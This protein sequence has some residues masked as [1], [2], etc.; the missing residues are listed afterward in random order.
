[1]DEKRI[2][3]SPEM[4]YREMVRDFN[5]PE[6]AV[7]LV[8]GADFFYDEE[9]KI[10]LGNFPG[11]EDI[12]YLTEDSLKYFS[13]DGFIYFDRS[14]DYSAK[15]DYFENLK[16]YLISKKD[17]TFYNQLAQLPFSLIISLSPDDFMHQ[18]YNEIGKPHYFYY[19]IT[20][21][22]G[23]AGQFKLPSSESDS[24]KPVDEAI[25]INQKIG[26]DKKKPLILNMF[27]H[28]DNQESLLLTHDKFFEY[29]H[30]S[31]ID[32]IPDN[33]R[34]NI[35][36][37]ITSFLIIGTHFNKWYLRFLFFLLY[38]LKP[39]IGTRA[40]FNYSEKYSN[41]LDFY[42]TIFQ[43]RFSKTDNIEF[44][45]GLYEDCKTKGLIS[46]DTLQQSKEA[47]I[48]NLFKFGDLAA[49]L[50]LAE[51]QY[52]EKSKE[53]INMLGRYNDNERHPERI[54][55]EQTKENIRT[56]MQNEIPCLNS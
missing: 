19:Y 1:M 45:N 43:M 41:E 36:T 24:G 51:K 7:G 8:L 56:D 39:G 12:P 46:K 42:Y 54:T 20:G 27:G 17:R 30:S 21:K 16:S 25:K 6:G 18:A 52:P 40:I 55:Y 29:L 26:A 31:P 4:I 33:I 32:E 37:N 5:D 3:V 34:A 2:L 22:E 13:D 49:C 44:I 28:F 9:Q 10:N 14:V 35:K 15:R 23:G 38:R 11:I 47:E 50:A 53:I 48:K